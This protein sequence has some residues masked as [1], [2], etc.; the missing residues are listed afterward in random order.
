[1]QGIID[2]EEVFQFH[3]SAFAVI[4]RE[5]NEGE[6]GIPLI[7]EDH[8]ETGERNE[9]QRKLCPFVCSAE[10]NENGEQYAPD[11]VIH[12]IIRI[13][14]QFRKNIGKEEYG[15]QNQRKEDPCI[16]RSSLECEVQCIDQDDGKGKSDQDTLIK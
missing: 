4:E 11:A 2:V 7:G 13:Y 8:S 3:F 6:K 14:E 12:E 10:I 5:R 1:M 16:V 9:A 15:G